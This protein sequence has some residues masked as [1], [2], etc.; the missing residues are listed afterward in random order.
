MIALEVNTEPTVVDI[1]DTGVADTAVKSLA[2]PTL[3]M[4]KVWGRHLRIPA[5]T[6]E[7]HS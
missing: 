5:R 1:P 4:K 7:S 2:E 3:V 6:L